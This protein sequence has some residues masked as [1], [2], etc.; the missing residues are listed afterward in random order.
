MVWVWLMA[1]ITIFLLG[2]FA[3]KLF[4]GGT[5]KLVVSGGDHGHGHSDDGSAGG[6]D[7]THASASTTTDT[8]DTQQAGAS[9]ANHLAS[10]ASSATAGDSASNTSSG[11]A[12]GAASNT[13]G[14]TASGTASNT[15]GSTVSGATSN[16]S[17]SAANSAVSSTSGNATSGAASNTS[18]STASGGSNAASSSTRSSATGA[19][20]AAGVTAAASAAIAGTMGSSKVS[21]QPGPQNATNP[22]VY[23]N[24]TAGSA[25]LS[26]GNGST[27]HASG[28][29]DAIA[30]EDASSVR[31]MIKIL[32]LRDSDAS[33]LGIDK[34][35]F[36]SLWQGSNA[37]VDASVLSSV[38]SRLM[39]MMS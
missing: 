20:A 14:S 34:T 35:Q 36:E 37:G 13:S 17:S 3:Y 16:T 26:S 25:I 18:S 12:S 7:D 15:S 19:V 10:T 21:P 2:W 5:P 4:S 11:S 38:R 33:R 24:V 8:A 23:E 29:T 39:H 32:N 22:I 31:E 27:G 6:H 28:V 30:S 1:L 9:D